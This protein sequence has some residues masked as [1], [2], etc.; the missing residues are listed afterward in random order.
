MSKGTAY[1][2]ETFASYLL[3]VTEHRQLNENLLCLLYVQKSELINKPHQW[4]AALHRAGLL[5][6]PVELSKNCDSS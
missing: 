2:A 3:K 4:A 1:P 6:M 5:R